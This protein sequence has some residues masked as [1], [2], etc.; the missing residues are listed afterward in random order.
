MEIFDDAWLT[1]P[2]R[3]WR[4]GISEQAFAFYV[5]NKGLIVVVGCSHPGVDNL[6]IKAKEISKKNVYLIIGGYH[7]PSKE[8]L[9]RIAKL[10][11]F[12]AP[13]HC[14]GNLAK[15]YVMEKFPDKYYLVRTG[16]IIIL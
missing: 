9:D 8:S 14:S 12:I 5:E 7:G 16:T 3:T 10:S 1:G 4:W 13:A 2:L 6:A 15:K 11:R